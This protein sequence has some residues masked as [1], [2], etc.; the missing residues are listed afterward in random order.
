MA[1]RVDL[2]KSKSSI[3][4]SSS[5]SSRLTDDLVEFPPLSPEDL[6]RLG[7]D[8]V[9][10][11]PIHDKHVGYPWHDERVSLISDMISKGKTSPMG[12]SPEEA[13]LLAEA[14]RKVPLPRQIPSQ[15]LMPLVISPRADGKDR[16]SVR[17]H[18][19]EF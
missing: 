15:C 2:S 5:S 6:I 17:S 16:V 12:L 14:I 18:G 1:Y 4:L 7:E 10:I 13:T 3:Q 9:H 19:P 11:Y 8:L